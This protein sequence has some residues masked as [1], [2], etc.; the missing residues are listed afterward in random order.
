MI[1]L[2]EL[3]T[4]EIVAVEDGRRLGTIF[5]LE[6]DPDNGKIA[7]LI[8]MQKEGTGLFKKSEEMMIYWNQILTIGTDV[9]LVKTAN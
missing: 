8:V 9:I 2:S 3:Q 6:I 7:A 1:R 4:L 5:D